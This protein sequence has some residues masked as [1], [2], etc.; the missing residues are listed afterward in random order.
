MFPNFKYG[1]LAD[2]FKTRLPKEL[3]FQIEADNAIRCGEIF[4]NNPNV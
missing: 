3:D 1:W 4:A 2:E